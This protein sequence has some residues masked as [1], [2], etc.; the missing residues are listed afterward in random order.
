[1]RA[2]C[3]KCLTIGN[4]KHESDW[5]DT[6]FDWFYEF[7]RLFRLAG[8][9]N[10]NESFCVKISL[11]FLNTTD[12]HISDDLS[13]KWYLVNTKSIDDPYSIRNMF[14]TS[15]VSFRMLFDGIATTTNRRKTTSFWDK[16]I[17][18]HVFLF[19][20][21]WHIANCNVMHKTRR[22]HAK[23]F[24]HAE[25]ITVWINRS[26]NYTPCND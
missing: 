25:S 19:T 9:A 13:A 2:I 14:Y 16:L 11:K 7:T 4:V 18:T 24:S 23:L 15:L 10:Q 3:E 20:T 26:S 12:Y 8:W 6:T 5:N 17:R 21:N 1:M 22:I